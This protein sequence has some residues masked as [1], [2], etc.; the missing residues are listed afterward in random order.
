MASS[1]HSWTCLINTSIHTMARS[2][3]G[4]LHVCILNRNMYEE[5]QVHCHWLVKTRCRG[6]WTKNSTKTYTGVTQGF[7]NRSSSSSLYNRANSG[8]LMDSRSSYRTNQKQI[9]WHSPHSASCTRECLHQWLECK[10]FQCKRIT[11]MCTGGAFASLVCKG[12]T[13]SAKAQKVRH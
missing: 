7:H 8:R 5:M 1:V 6:R 9:M 4:F 10:H 12:D 11:T 3:K 2:A 13:M